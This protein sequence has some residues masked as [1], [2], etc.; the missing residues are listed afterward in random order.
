MHTE[1][2]LSDFLNLDL[3]NGI[4]LKCNHFHL[5]GSLVQMERVLWTLQGF[6]VVSPWAS[7]IQMHQDSIGQFTLQ[8]CTFSSVCQLQFSE[9][10][11]FSV[12]SESLGLD[13]AVGTDGPTGKR[14]GGWQN[15]LLESRCSLWEVGIF[16]IV[17]M[18]VAVRTVSGIIDLVSNWL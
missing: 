7:G 9:M 18:V 3:I 14:L 12:C 2:C 6:Q 8:P 15:Q 11:R 1:A 13:W 16:W 5:S 17:A 4:N 10:E